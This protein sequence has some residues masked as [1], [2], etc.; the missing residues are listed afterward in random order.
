[1]A[2]SRSASNGMD[3]THSSPYQTASDPLTIYC[4]DCVENPYGW[5]LM[6]RC[7][8]DYKIENGQISSGTYVRHNRTYHELF[9]VGE[10]TSPGVWT[11]ITRSTQV[12]YEVHVCSGCSTF[13]NPK[14]DNNCFETVHAYAAID[15]RITGVSCLP[16]YNFF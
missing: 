12:R 16:G 14:A 8:Y 7:S 2:Q 5:D 1:M 9:F 11:G 3:H 15:T 6:R 13:C 10:S 4:M